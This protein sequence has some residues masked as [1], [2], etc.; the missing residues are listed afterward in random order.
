MTVTMSK[1]KRDELVDNLLVALNDRVEAAGEPIAVE[2][3]SFS[4]ETDT[5]LL[6]ILNV[7]FEEL[8]VALDLCLSRR[9]LKHQA[10]GGGKYGYLGLTEEG[11]GRAISVDAARRNPRP[12]SQAAGDIHI[13]TLN[14]S[15]ATQIGHHNTQNIESLFVSLIEAINNADAADEAKQEAKSR[16]K[17]FLEHPL[18]NTIIGSAVAAALALLRGGS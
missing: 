6:E 13:T 2:W 7:S 4:R 15:G 14:A 8:T 17:A 12:T 16:L 3:F 5:E 18:T 11:H 1:E 10:M 9:Y